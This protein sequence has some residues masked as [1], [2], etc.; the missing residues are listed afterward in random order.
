MIAGEGGGG[1]FLSWNSDGQDFAG[2]S[3]V[4]RRY[5]VAEESRPQIALTDSSADPND[6][7]IPF[8]DYAPNTASDW[9]TVT[10][11]NQGNAPWIVTKL[12]LFGPA[13][14]SCRLES[15]AAF[16]LAPAHTRD[17]RA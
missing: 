3:A 8:G 13:A 10:V 1:F 14:A 9:Q 12:E 15:T 6:H 7:Y 17:V 11:A 5:T 2:Q 16:S 4:A